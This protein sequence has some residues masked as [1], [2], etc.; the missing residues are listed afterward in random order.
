MDTN[1]LFNIIFKDNNVFAQFNKINEQVN[2]VDKSI[3]KVD[4]SIRTK[5]STVNLEAISSQVE[6]AGRAFSTLAAPGVAFEA[7]MAELSAITGIVGSDLDDLGVRAKQVGA[8][9]G[10]GASQAAQAY[11][12]LASQIE[13]SKIGMDGLNELQDRSITL[14]KASGMGIEDAA[15]SLA[16]TINQ[17]GLAAEDADR[18]INVLAAGSKYGAAE[19]PELAQSFKVVG[20]AANAAGL[21]VEQTAGAIEVLSKNNLKGAEA[22]TALRNIVL[23]MQTQLG[24]DFGETSLSQALGDLKP[25]LNDATYLS[26]LFGMENVAAAQFMIANSEAVDEMTQNVTGS[27]VAHEQAA[28]MSDTV[29]NRMARM[30]ATME[31]VSIGVFNATGGMIGYLGI[32]G[33]MAGGVANLVPIFSAFGSILGFV[34]NA[35]KMQAMWSGIV[36]V[37]TGIWAGVQWALNASLLGCPLLLLV[38]LIGML[39]A[40][41]TWCAMNTE[42]WGKQWDSVVNFMKFTFMAYVDFVKLYFTTVVNGIMIGLDYIKLGWYKF[43]EACGI[44]DS[45]ENKSAIAKINADVEARQ[46]AIVDGAKKVAENVNNAKK[47]LTWEIKI[48]PEEPKDSDIQNKLALSVPKIPGI[49]DDK[50]TKTTDITTTDTTKPTK[51]D[52]KKT[53][54]TISQ[55]GSKSNVTNINLGN[56]VENIIFNGGGFGDNK[57]DLTRQ[58]E[59]AFVRVLMMA[60]SVS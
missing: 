29:A 28:I 14:A 41:I 60:R 12:I 45:A 58:I 22:G 16:G 35:E 53:T 11:K 52:T 32:I 54:E 30:R 46:K 20:A 5:L 8:D 23:K 57:D 25:K 37:A 55:G 50:T 47:A 18:V 4:S 51:D 44:G 19:I 43:K 40:A 56:M 27:N 10:L 9:S 49:I 31:N 36:S 13:V 1:I 21:S 59:E 34:T 48:K 15:N 39:V 2:N 3:N 42:G 6:R 17:F 38:A 33:E 24:V 7:S 26:K